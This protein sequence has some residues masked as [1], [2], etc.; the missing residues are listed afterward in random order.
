MKDRT[1]E[2]SSRVSRRTLSFEA[3]Y[4]DQPSYIM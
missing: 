2:S 4:T 3:G 1:N